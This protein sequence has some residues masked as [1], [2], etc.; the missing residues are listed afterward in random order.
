M[1][2]AASLPV[3][4]YYAVIF[5]SQRSASDPA[6]YSAAAARMLDL[7]AL[8][9]GFLGV[10]SA[11]G[12]EGLGVT[13]SYWQDEASIAAWKRDAEHAATRDR[14]RKAWYDAFEVRVARVERAYGGGQHR[15]A[16]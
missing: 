7:A 8:Q 1:I 16:A 13:V 4:P 9:S 11:R 6:E 3:P 2:R 14:G 15:P 10:D 5:V 12:E